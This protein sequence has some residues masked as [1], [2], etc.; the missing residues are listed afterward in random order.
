MDREVK[1]DCALSNYGASA[2][3]YGR[4]LVHV[5]MISCS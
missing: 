5:P 3:L 1:G 2:K 4:P